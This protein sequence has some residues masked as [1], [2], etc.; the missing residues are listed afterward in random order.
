MQ[1]QHFFNFFF[2]GVRIFL[3][4]FNIVKTKKNLMEETQ[5]FIKKI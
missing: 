2:L 4:S 1:Q 3:F 5:N